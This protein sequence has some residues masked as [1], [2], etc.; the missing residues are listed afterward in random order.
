MN[1][2]IKK[3]VLYAALLVVAFSLWNAWQQYN[4]HKNA[5]SKAAQVVN[6]APQNQPQP[7]AAQNYNNVQ[8]NHKN[9]KGGFSKHIPQ[10]R[11]VEVKTDTLNF[12]IDKQ[13]GNIIKVE[14]PKYSQKL[15]QPDKP[16][17]LLTANPQKFY[18]AQSKLVGKQGPDSEQNQ[19]QYATDQSVYKLNPNEKQ[20]TVKL[21]W[22]NKQGLSVEKVY[23]FQR[24]KYAVQMNYHIKNNTAQPWQGHMVLQIDR[25]KPEQAN[26]HFLGI[27]AFYGAAVSSPD[28]RYQKMGFS[29]L[30]KNP[31]SKTIKNGWAAMIQ[32]YFLSAWVPEKQQPYHYFSQVNNNIY[33]IGLA[34]QTFK[35][36]PG[37]EHTVSAHFY[38]GPEI[39]SRLEQVAPGLKLTISYGWLWFISVI[40]FWVMKHI[41]DIIG[42]WGWSIVLVTVLIKLMFYQLSA[43]SYRSMAKMRKLQPKIKAL[44]ERHGEDKQKQSQAM[45]ELYKKEKVNPLSGCL[46]ILIQLPVFFALYSVLIETVQLRHAPWMLWIQDLSAPDPYFILPVLMGLSMLLQQKLNPPPPDP[47]QEKVMMVLPVVFT[48]VFVYFPA[49]LVLYWVVNN[50]LSVL[51]QWYI[52]R[53]YA[54]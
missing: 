21:H 52:T 11:L 16:I 37:G 25:R 3:I 2:Q 41:H 5:P 10:K 48:V 7:A 45:M 50:L 43:K 28:K 19:A 49:G 47:T 36:S 51:Q 31:V 30:I 27:H 38:A 12:Y 39:A 6:N 40:V 1:E 53:K 18:I 42:N 54:A 26:S 20:L 35:V 15:N 46:P 29:D 14:L 44:R 23:Q 24:D 32:R 34:G 17:Q 4:S 13:G 22:H 9:V 33:T 8:A